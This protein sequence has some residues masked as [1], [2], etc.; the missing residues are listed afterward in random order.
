MIQPLCVTE[1]NKKKTQPLVSGLDPSTPFFSLSLSLTLSAFFF[2]TRIYFAA[3]LAKTASSL[4]VTGLAGSALRRHS[5]SAG[6]VSTCAAVP[7]SSLLAYRL[8]PLQT[9][10]QILKCH[11]FSSKNKTCVISFHFILGWTT[12]YIRTACRNLKD[13]ERERERER[14]REEEKERDS[15]PSFTFAKY[16]GDDCHRKELQGEREKRRKK[17]QQSDTEREA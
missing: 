10:V 17:R 7:F 9:T 14:E 1:E 16:A 12:R 3:T 2:P 11:P 15:S 13:S 5:A 6:V 8:S 4:P